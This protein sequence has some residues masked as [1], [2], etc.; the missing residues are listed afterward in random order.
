MVIVKLSALIYNSEAAMLQR[1]MVDATPRGYCNAAWLLQRG[2]AKRIDA[3][4]PL[5]QAEIQPPV[6]DPDAQAPILGE[7]MNR[8]DYRA[9]S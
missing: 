3:I 2:V 5:S 1:R 6:I 8:D 4:A 9:E 7:I